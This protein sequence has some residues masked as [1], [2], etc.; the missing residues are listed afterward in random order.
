MRKRFNFK[1]KAGFRKRRLFRRRRILRRNVRRPGNKLVWKPSNN[2]PLPLEYYTKVRAKGQGFLTTADASPKGFGGSYKW[3]FN[4]FTLNNLYQP[5]AAL[6]TGAV[7]QVDGLNW[8]TEPNL[9]PIGHLTLCNSTTYR[10]L[11]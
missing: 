2:M 10:I 11:S 4:G 8:A 5:F 3:I 9:Q 7:G 1:R 6:Q